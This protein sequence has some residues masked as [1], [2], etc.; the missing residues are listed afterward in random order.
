MSHHLAMFGGH[1]FSASEDINS[2]HVTLVNHV[3]EGSSNFMDGSSSWYV[4][5][6]PS[7]EDLDFVVVDI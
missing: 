7:L 5:T 4:T 1:W 2:C 6:L 3:I